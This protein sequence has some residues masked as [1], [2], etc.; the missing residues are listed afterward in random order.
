M[1][2]A[3]GK[4]N[5]GCGKHYLVKNSTICTIHP[6][7]Y[8]YYKCLRVTKFSS[9]GFSTLCTQSL[10]RVR[11]NIHTS[12]R[13]AWFRSKKLVCGP[14]TPRADGEWIIAEIQYSA[15][16]VLCTDRQ[17]HWM[18]NGLRSYAN[19]KQIFIEFSTHLQNHHPFSIRRKLWCEPA[20][21]GWGFST[22]SI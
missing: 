2:N 13:C 4:A 1:K 22:I 5:V 19:S 21:S 14:F 11:T 15:L 10:K 16:L 17:T 20:V 9:K 3:G 7:I 18:Q 6:Y 12:G 8:I